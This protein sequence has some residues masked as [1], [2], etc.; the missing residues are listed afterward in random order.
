VG[1]GVNGDELVSV[2]L[3]DIPVRLH[4]RATEHV[5]GLRREFRLLHEYTAQTGD[6]SVPRRLLDLVQAL[7]TSY[8]G[9]TAEQ[10]DHLEQAIAAGQDRVTLTFRVPAHA[11]Q[12][13]LALGAM[14]DE[15]DDFCRDGQHLLTLA[16]P[17]DVVAYRRWYLGQFVDQIHGVPPVP[18]S[19]GGVAS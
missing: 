16:S 13:A 15:A 8:A 12:A 11:A 6:G 4:V 19:R 7:R 14:L 17:D 10:E 1:G 3:V 2:S 18:W 5:E 9:F